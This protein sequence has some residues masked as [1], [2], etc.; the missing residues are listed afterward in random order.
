VTT[1]DDAQRKPRPTPDADSAAFWASL[2]QGRLLLQHC[3]DCAHVQYYQQGLCRH[4]LSDRLE[5]RAASGRGTV[6]TY[7]VV[8]RAPG[9]AF[10]RDTPY[11]VLLVDLEEGPRM[12]STLTQGDPAQLRI[13][14]AVQLVCER[15][16]DTLTLPRFRPVA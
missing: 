1:L 8:H 2:A 13:G 10:A 4:C 3:L 6:H 15:V 5:H 11:A 16:D 9:P 12:I 14:M 7:S